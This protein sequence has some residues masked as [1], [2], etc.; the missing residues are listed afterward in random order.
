MENYQNSQS[1]ADS[2]KIKGVI[3]IYSLLEA[4]VLKR[5]KLEVN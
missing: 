3:Q 5:R 4:K 1:A 2:S